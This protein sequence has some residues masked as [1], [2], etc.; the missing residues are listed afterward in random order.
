MGKVEWLR[1]YRYAEPGP[2]F[3]EDQEL[4]LRSH[5]RSRFAT[6]DEI[7]FAYRVRGKTNWPKLAKTHRAVLEVQIRHFS[8]LNQWHYVGLATAAYLAKTA[9]DISRRLCAGNNGCKRIGAD[10]AV[11]SGWNAILG[12]IAREPKAP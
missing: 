9:R 6:I 1:K 4:L 12:G 5:G 10:D 8:K 2:Y 3:C 11:V 7:L